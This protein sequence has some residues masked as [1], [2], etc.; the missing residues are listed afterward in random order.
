MLN[1][2]GTPT[3]SFIDKLKNIV[4]AFAIAMA[5]AYGI[6]YLLSELISPNQYIPPAEFT[7]FMSCVWAPLWEEAVFRYAP[8][9]IASGVNPSLVWPV[10]I[11]SA[12]IFGWGH[13]EY[14]AL[15][16]LRE[17]GAAV[18][19]SFLFIKNNN[20]YWSTV[21]L[22]SAWNCMVFFMNN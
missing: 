14:G 20:S 5:W 11:I 1:F 8:I 9:K 21:L 2:L 7:F 10:I 6:T 12:A 18:I 17:G 13:N 16:V 4:F 22:H 3:T 15:G 19:F